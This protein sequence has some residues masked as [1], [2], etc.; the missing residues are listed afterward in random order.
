[1][2]PIHYA[3][4]ILALALSSCAHQ[5]PRIA[6]APVVQADHAEPANSTMG[7]SDAMVVSNACS[8]PARQGCIGCQTAC[9]SNMVAYCA[10]GS[11][12]QA[13]VTVGVYEW[14]CW[15]PAVCSCRAP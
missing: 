8:A 2:K 13:L 4:C 12:Y 10:A 1:M 3:L 7:T 11:G 5:K 14:R 6:E 9:P 15:A